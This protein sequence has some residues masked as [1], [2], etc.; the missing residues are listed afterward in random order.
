ME[1]LAE[2]S[3]DV[4]QLVAVLRRD[5]SSPYCFLRIAAVYREADRCEEAIE[6]AEQGLDAFPGERADSRLQEFLAEAY[7][8]EGRHR[9]ALE[10]A[11]ERFADH[12]GLDSYRELKRYAEQV[13]EWPRRRERALGLLRKRARE[14]RDEAKRL[15]YR[16]LS[17]GD[18]SQLVR[19][20]LWEG[21]VEVAW[22]E[23]E[24]GGCEESLW[25]DLAERRKETH[26]EDALRVYRERIEPAIERKTKRDYED[27]V[28]LIEEVGGLLRRL[29]REQELPALVGE[30]RAAHARKRNL[31]ALLDR[32][33]LEAAHSP[34][35]SR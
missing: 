21:E 34:A 11:W 7:A 8:E 31:I 33:G 9:D 10:V 17:G 22:R 26:P 16:W 14:A 32:A 23:A 18:H 35:G 4:E 5:L 25:L 27:A 12:P 28:G 24:A 6:W 19:V 1:R 3:R 20:L 30:I 13:E 15:R 29:G 2:A